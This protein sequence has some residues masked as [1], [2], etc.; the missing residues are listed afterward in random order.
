MHGTD[1]DAEKLNGDN[2]EDS[3]LEEHMAHWADV[4]DRWVRG[5]D[6]QLGRQEGVP[7]TPL[8]EAEG[9]AIAEQ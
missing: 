6:T 1:M 7:A 9:G 5:I 3:G 4:L 2:L 8:E